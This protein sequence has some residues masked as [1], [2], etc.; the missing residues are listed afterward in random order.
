MEYLCMNLSF[1]QDLDRNLI[2]LAR[3]T[4]N[5]IDYV[6]DA[7][8]LQSELLLFISTIHNRS[9]KIICSL[10]FNNKVKDI[11]SILFDRRFLF[12]S[13]WLGALAFLLGT[14][15]ILFILWFNGFFILIVERI[16]PYSQDPNEITQR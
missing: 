7:T 9:C 16:L 15:L 8:V 5:Q 14:Y 13:L 11:V 6:I 2:I 1:L 10:P 4:L 3:L 12:N